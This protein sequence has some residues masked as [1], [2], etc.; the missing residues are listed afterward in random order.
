MALPDYQTLMLPVLKV[1][2]D[3]QEHRIGDVVNQLAR[4]FGL[5]EEEQQQILPSGRQATFANR[6][7]CGACQR[8]LDKHSRNLLNFSC[9][10]DRLVDPD[11]AGKSR[12]CGS[13]SYE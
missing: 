6:V 12:W 9:V 13:A 1:A 7:G 4:E 2:G 8:L 10:L 3:G 5:T 11:L